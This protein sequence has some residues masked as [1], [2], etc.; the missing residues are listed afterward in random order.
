ME[1]T[2]ILVLIAFYIYLGLKKPGVALITSPFVAGALIVTGIA[3]ENPLIMTGAPLIFIET[4]ILSL[5]SKS[6][7][8]Y[9]AQEWSR[10]VAR[11]VL[12]SISIALVLLTAICCIYIAIEEEETLPLIIFIGLIVIIIPLFVMR[13]I[14]VSATSNT[15]SAFVLST[16]GSSIRQNLPLPMA[17]ESAAG[18]WQD[19]G[20][21]I[22]QNIKKWL[23]QGYSLSESIKRGYPK[24]P[25]HAVAMIAA[26]ER[27]D[28]LPLALKAIEANIT[29]QT[30]ENRKI[31][32]IHPL[33][34]LVVIT[35]MI[36]IIIGVMAFVIPSF[37]DTL[38]EMTGQL[39][40]ITRILLEITAFLFIEHG[41]LFGIFVLLIILVTIPASIYFR[42]RARRPDKPFFMTR[43]G[44]FIK[45][46]LPVLHWFERNYSMVQVV[47]ML[48]LSLNAGCPVNDAIQNTIG[49][50]V[51][52]RFK[53]RL[54][55]WHRKVEQGDN[56]SAAARKSKLS[57]ALA[58]AFDEQ[59]NQGN[60]PA[61]LETLEAFYRSNYSYCVNLAR[62][63]IWP[64]IIVCMGIVVCFVVLA[65]FTPSIE[66]INSLA[67]SVAP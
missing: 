21:R 55:K 60:T 40:A 23:V 64:C 39:P 43:I 20:S 31:R 30:R 4:I 47:D 29:A 26:A 35:F 32:P 41:Q 51:N 14:I 27:I 62:F 58:W 37:K 48:R 59:I 44:D 56:I 54:K 25:G 33:Y 1:I 9:E 50:D 28:Q 10:S 49:L 12:S 2:I 3:T 52:N 38:T 11:I 57:S 24:C 42:F 19:K 8:E 16:I 13:I 18:G 61:I 65:I 36:L 7:Y 22:L 6:K 66:I 34:P 17:L 67:G 63:I 15:T 45:W 46:H 5:L 53:R